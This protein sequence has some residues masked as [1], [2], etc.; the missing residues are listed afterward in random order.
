M[1]QETTKKRGRSVP[2]FPNPLKP[3]A[4]PWTPVRLTLRE[5]PQA[6]LGPLGVGS[7]CGD[8]GPVLIASHQRLRTETSGSEVGPGLVPS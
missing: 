6:A 2:T 8:S 1:I 5:P 7:N 3:R 4:P